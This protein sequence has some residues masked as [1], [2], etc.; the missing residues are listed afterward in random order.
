MYPSLVFDFIH[1]SDLDSWN[2]KRKFKVENVMDDVF[3]LAYYLKLEMCGKIIDFR[4]LPDSSL[5]K[6]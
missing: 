6:K 1:S 4:R 2:Y 5:Q 3:R